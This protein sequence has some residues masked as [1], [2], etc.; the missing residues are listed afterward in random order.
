MSAH[1]VSIE[2]RRAPH[3][4][5]PKTYARRHQ[6]HLNGGQT[7]NVSASVDYKGEADCA[8][9]EQL[10]VNAVSSCHM[11]FFLAIAELQGFV[12]DEYRDTAT[13]YLEKQDGGMAI[14]RIE[15]APQ[16]RFGGEKLPDYAVMQR[17]HAGAHKHCFIARSLKATVTIA[18]AA[19]QL[20]SR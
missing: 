13:G 18:D 15:L 8:D 20:P 5:E 16:V 2:W 9:P 11:L 12:V 4:T 1:T 10:L 7:L 17:M 6:S 19:A 14:T 3:E